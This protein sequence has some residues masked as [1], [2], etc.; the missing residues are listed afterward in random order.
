[1]TFSESLKQS[2]KPILEAQYK[3]KFVQGLGDGSLSLDKFRYYMI[4]DTLYIVEYARAMAWVA[5]LMSDVQDT[6]LMLDAA[7]ES[8]KIEAMLKENSFAKFGITMED[9]LKAEM[10]PNCKSYVDHLY[11]YTRN[12]S[13]AEAMAAIIPCGWIYV[14]IGAQFTAGKEIAD[15]HPYKEWL[16]TYAVPEFQEMVNWWFDILDKSIKELPDAQLDQIKDIFIKS[17]QYEWMFWDMGWHE[18]KWQ[19]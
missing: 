19:P 9:A 13:L 15:T 7:N 16:M 2:A 6:I 1:M 12:G 11:R 10:A 8:F 4:Q 3:H 5:T 18:Q 17:C 14:E